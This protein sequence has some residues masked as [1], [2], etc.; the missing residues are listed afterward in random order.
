MG[1]RLAALIDTVP[2]LK[3]AAAVEK[4]G[5]SLLGSPCGPRV[6]ISADLDAA[7]GD[8]DVAIDFSA[9]EAAA[10]LAER[11]GRRKVRLV[12]GTTGLSPGD[13]RRVEKVAQQVACVLSPNMSPGMNLLFR[14][15]GTVVR[16]LGEEFDAEVIEAHHRHKK[17]APSGTALRL[18][19]EIA[20]A[21]GADLKSLAVY[22]RH[23]QAERKAGEIGIQTI[24]AGDIVGDHTV[25]L[26]GP[27]ERL[28]LTHR[29]HSRD[30]FARGALLAARW[31]ADRP[32]GLYDM[33][34][35]LGLS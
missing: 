35:V 22:A 9:P 25:L 1:Q 28:E 14:I 17:D 33:G 6:K 32:P 16:A 24:R 21:R 10:D 27:G 13:R 20:R 19:E 11:A 4:K 30:A 31:V 7:L 29:A 8:C 5:H 15:V 23:G 18:A 3:L 34:D 12:V 26:G 2:G